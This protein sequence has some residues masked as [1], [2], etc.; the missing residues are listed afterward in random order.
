MHIDAAPIG[1][2]LQ[3]FQPYGTLS[4]FGKIEI[5]API[6]TTII[7]IIIIIII[8]TTTTMIIIIIII[9]IIINIINKN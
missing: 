9:I 7:I 2:R 1:S 8:T 4:R 5:N 3:S 6:N